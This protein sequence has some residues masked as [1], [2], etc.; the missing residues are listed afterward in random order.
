M[1]FQNLGYNPQVST[2]NLPNGVDN[3]NSGI[4]NFQSPAAA[5][6]D[7]RNSFLPPNLT[8]PYFNAA[9]VHG[10][11]GT[12]TGSMTGNAAAFMNDTFSPELSALNQ[13][14]ARNASETASRLM[15]QGMVR[16]EDQ[17]ENSPFHSAL[18]RAQ[19]EVMNQFARDQMNLVGQ[20][21]Q[22]QQQIG[23]QLAQF[24]FTSTA[25]SADQGMNIS[26]R[27]WNMGNQEFNAPMQSALAYY[28]AAP[29][30]APVLS[31]QSSGG[32]K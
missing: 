17:F 20:L 32:S 27:L 4:G 11:L 31:P 3:P 14:T 10:N 13:S 25:Q 15:E 12:L 2:P 19:G 9:A 28:N 24:P 30:T 23:A 8:A 1:A 22:Q 6:T 5:S 18:P 29:F 16:Q 26:E 21:G 7:T